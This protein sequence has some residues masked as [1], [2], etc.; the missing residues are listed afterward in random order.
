MIRPKK[1][2]QD[3][4]LRCVSHPEKLGLSK[5][6]TKAALRVSSVFPM[7][8]PRPLFPLMDVSDPEDPIRKQLI[9]NIREL[10]GDGDP[11][12]LDETSFQ[13]G[14]GLI[15]RFEDRL[16]ALVSST[17]P[18]LCRHCN[19]KRTWKEPM[20]VASSEEIARA[21]SRLPAI[22]EVIL[23]GGEPLL[24]SDRTLSSLLEAASSGKNVQNI[25][26]HTRIPFSLPSRIQTPLVRLLRSHQPT[27][28]V[29]HFNH[30]REVH[31]EAQKALAL[32]REAG[33]PLL[34]Q[35]V[36]LRGINDSV[37]A[38]S[39]LG[40]AL[41]RAGVK[42]HYLFQLDRARGTLHFQVPLRKSLQIIS[43]LHAR[44]SGLIVPHL[45]ADLPGRG[46]KVPLLPDA[47]IRFTKNG[48]LLRGSDG[49]PVLYREG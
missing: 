5:T 19:R 12:P 7:R 15:R 4:L 37:A 44:H 27:W 6:A 33:I 42:P 2:W 41:V 45:L 3:E 14:P 32:L 20:S 23:S 28:I 47:V 29:T 39:E 9:P 11:D 26:I 34:N 46:G 43:T 38:Q 24:L 22:R 8:I 30:A 1:H 25:R 31:K 48:A 10:D 13:I 36:L 17:C 16:L 49:T 21:L 18:L 40:W 35:A